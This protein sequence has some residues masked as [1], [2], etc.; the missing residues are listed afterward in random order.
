[1]ALI[2]N[3]DTL[4]EGEAV[5]KGCKYILRTEIMFQRVDTECVVDKDAYLQNPNYLKVKNSFPPPPPLILS[6]SH[7][8]L[9]FMFFHSFVFI[10]S[11]CLCSSF[12]FSYLISF[13]VFLFISFF[14][15]S[16][17]FIFLFY[18][19][20]FVLLTFFFLL[21]L[22]LLSLPIYFVINK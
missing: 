22:C 16:R 12:F 14:I 15:S 3:H 1:M 20:V 13:F 8:L 10:L 2:F 19:L 11:Y 6:T 5:T 7:L 4:H 18:T 9:F 17:S 21:V